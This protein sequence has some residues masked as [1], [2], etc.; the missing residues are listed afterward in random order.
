VLAMPGSMWKTAGVATIGVI[1]SGSWGTALAKLLAESGHDVTMWAFEPE[2][3]RAIT[4]LHE[5]TVYL[6]GIKLPA[7][8]Q[9]TNELAEAVRGKELLVSVSPSHVV[10]GVMSDAAR[11]VTGSPYIVS[12]TKGVE[13][14]SLLTMA[15]VLDQ[16]MG[17]R[18]AEWICALSGPSF[19][20]EVANGMPTAVTVAAR[21]HAVSET[22]QRIF[23]A[24]YFRVYSSDD[25]IGVEIGGAVKNVIALAAGVSDGLGFGANTRAAL[26]TRG[27]AE[28]GR[29]GAKL[30][31]N[32]MTLS[33]LAGLGDLVLTCTGDLSRNRT[34]GLRLGHGESLE[35]ILADM[36]MVAEGVKNTHSVRDLAARVGVEMPI[37]EQMYA[38]LYEH[39]PPRQAVSDLMQRGLKPEFDRPDGGR[40]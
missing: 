35:A 27:L 19:A 37:T 13:E 29:L 34:V 28:I 5:N 15:S 39:K 2:V 23:N 7:T 33:G 24:S 6:P 31:A 18:H 10:R 32:P 16:A 21:T 26:I 12:A 3:R 4:D 9:T 40:S 36:K 1:G 11:H 22:V 20:R 38:V 8:L 30:G 25:V 14:G 17:N